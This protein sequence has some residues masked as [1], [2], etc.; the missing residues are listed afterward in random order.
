MVQDC[1]HL[2]VIAMAAKVRKRRRKKKE[3]RGDK[4][5]PAAMP[6]DL[7]NVATGMTRDISASGIF[8][9]TNTEYE[10]GNSIV[11]ALEFTTP[12]GRLQFR[13]QG[14]IV[15]VEQH[16]SRMGVAVKIAESRLRYVQ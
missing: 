7:A 6:V 2:Y 8:F 11:M 10:P 16:D 13:C 12:A 3:M 5:I 4:R 15:R 1:L 9:E 14:V